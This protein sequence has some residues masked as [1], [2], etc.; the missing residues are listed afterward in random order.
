MPSSSPVHAQFFHLTDNSI[1]WSVLWSGYAPYCMFIYIYFWLFRFKMELECCG[2]N[3][4]AQAQNPSS[5]PTSSS[6]Q[7]A[8]AHSQPMTPKHVNA[9]HH[10]GS[11]EDFPDLP[12]HFKDPSTLFVVARMDDVK[13]RMRC[14]CEVGKYD[15]TWWALSFHYRH[16]FCTECGRCPS[17]LSPR[18]LAEMFMAATYYWDENCANK[19]IFE[20]DWSV[21]C[22][23]T[24]SLKLLNA[25]PSCVCPCAVT[26]NPSDNESS[27][28]PAWAVSTEYLHAFCTRCGQAADERTLLFI[29]LTLEYGGVHN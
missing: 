25:K 13:K 4:P 7:G 19:Q 21:R 11:V 29:L 1:V 24:G 6:S 9:A 2:T 27:T 3:V 20:E 15:T 26:G 18:H 14:E 12:K 17:S 23:G 28:L 22:G 8:R 10:P 16:T 5:P